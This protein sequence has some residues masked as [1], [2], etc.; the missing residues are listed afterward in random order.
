M[1]SSAEPRIFR[2]RRVITPSSPSADAVA[3]LGDRIVAVGDADDLR[4][5]LPLARLVDLGD[6][7]VT[8]G[9]NDAHVHLSMAADSELQ[10]DVSP[11]E[12]S[13]LAELTA[14]I[15]AAA[16]S[17][18]ADG[19]VRAF[20]YDDARMAEGRRLTRWDLD[21]V[22]G[23]VPAIVLH[24]ACHW[25]VVNSAA[26]AAGG[27][28]DESLPPSGG[29]Y[30]RDA[31]GRLDGVLYERALN[32]FAYGHVNSAG[33]PVVPQSRFDDRVEAL[34]RVVRRWHAAGV[35]SVCDALVGPDDIRLF[36]EAREQGLLTMRVGF[37]LAAEHYDTL[38]RLGLRSGFG[39][40]GL[41]FVGVKTFAD[42]A[43]G[44]RTCLLDEPHHG[45]G[46]HGIQVLTREELADIVRAVHGDGNRV[47]VHA[48][49]DRAIRLVLDEL[50]RAHR[51]MPKPGLRHRI[52][53]CSLVDDDILGRIRALSAIA[54]PFGN[55]VHQHGG[56]LIDWYGE[57]RVERMFAHRSF[58]DAG[59]TVA[60]S[61]DYPCG[62][63]E[64]LLAM[65]SMVTRTG[66]D[67][68]VVGAGQRVSPAEALSVY[69]TGSAASTGEEGLKGSLVAGQ[70]AD[71]VVLEDDPLE[72]PHDQISKIG[73]RATYVGGTEVY[74]RE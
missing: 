63:V 55:Y 3:V 23:D 37:L 38:R 56:R 10:V 71:F 33:G 49:G 72:V 52:E 48:N 16:R 31:T 65:Q 39:D 34:G 53:H 62:P 28:T 59:V 46:D 60:G 7:V 17:E 47:C 8:P 30:G 6:A 70:L 54:V 25:G 66:W 44:G 42:G 19:W 35:T 26:L 13:S 57:S 24:V 4:R 29:E 41:R 2:A 18:P 14:K 40:A 22:T 36:A 27:I 12:V 58:L 15:G 43:V 9:F 20:G 32:E 61:S 21:A 74:V 67:G 68:S 64:P 11:A 51:D 73:V 5:S 50:E 45:T 1:H 69:T